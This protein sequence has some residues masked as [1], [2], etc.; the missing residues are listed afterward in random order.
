M[1]EINN[2]HHQGNVNSYKNRPPQVTDLS[3]FTI[4]IRCLTGML[5]VNLNTCN[6]ANLIWQT[7]TTSGST[8]LACH[9]MPKCTMLFRFIFSTIFIR[10]SLFRFHLVMMSKSTSTTSVAAHRMPKSTSTTSVAA[11]RM[12][13]STES[14]RPANNKIPMHTTLQNSIHKRPAKLLRRYLQ[15]SLLYI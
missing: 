14:S 6:L 10:E 4:T 3:T 1:I 11:H 7:I 5:K 8:K 12:P 13:K 2:F 15:Q 9:K